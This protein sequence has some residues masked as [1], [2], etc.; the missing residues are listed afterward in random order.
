MII[1]D[2][3][4]KIAF[5][6]R[7]SCLDH[8][9]NALYRKNRCPISPDTPNSCYNLKTCNY[10]FLILILNTCDTCKA[11]TSINSSIMK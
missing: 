5:L 8:L 7:F 1:M 4:S 11:E 9:Y 6:E 3:R 10:C 2:E